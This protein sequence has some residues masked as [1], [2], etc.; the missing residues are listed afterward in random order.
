MITIHNTEEMLEFYGAQ[1]AI[2][3]ASKGGFLYT[4]P[5]P[6]NGSFVRFWGNL[7][8][9]SA[10]S[11]D[12]T[13]PNDTVIRSLF[14]QRYLGIGL[15]DEGS[16]I[17]YNRKDKQQQLREGIN[18]YVFDSLTPYFMKVKG[19]ERLRF[20]ALY[21]QEQFFLENNVPLYDSFWRDAK[22]SIGGQPIHAPELVSIYHRIEKCR[23]TG[24]AFDTWMRGQGLEAAGYILNL[25]QK[26]SK[27]VPVNFDDNEMRTI[28]KAKS[29]LKANLENT[30]TILELCKLVCM[31]KNKLQEGFHI[32]EGKSIAE[33]VRTLRM[34]RALELLETSNLSMHEI[35]HAVGYH[36]ISNFYGTFNHTFGETPG[37][38][39]QIL[40]E[41]RN[42][43]SIES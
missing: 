3:T 1:G 19:G 4:F 8:G 27:K 29:M 38:I 18:C 24:P 7:Q 39:Q 30:P 20:R 10:A 23:L 13:Y 33:Y 11:A 16:V 40:R 34:E 26:Y 25:V 12:F 28:E 36:S 22:V 35:A 15:S 14:Q 17:S 21:F 32:T 6:E 9:F 2:R 37:L 42:P 41:K 5:F 31:N 43:N